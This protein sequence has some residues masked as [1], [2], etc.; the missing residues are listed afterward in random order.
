MTLLDTVI[1]GAGPAGMTAAI[2][3]KRKGMSLELISDST[4]GNMSKSGNIENYPGFEAISGSDLARKMR[5]QMERLG[6]EPVADRVTVVGRTSGGYSVTTHGGRTFE[7]RDRDHRLRLL[8]GGKSASPARKSTS[9]KASAIARPATHP[10]SQAQT[11]RS[12]AA[13]MQQPRRSLS[14]S[15]YA[16]RSI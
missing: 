9:V 6:V 13:A 12:S 5:T 10:C 7:A 15:R 16:R 11:W 14:C 8:T 4:G 3:A 2:Y 1:I